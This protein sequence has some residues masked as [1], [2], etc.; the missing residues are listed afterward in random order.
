MT[1]IHNGAV[2]AR[3]FR[4][5]CASALAVA[6]LAAPSAGAAEMV[7]MHDWIAD[8]TQTSKRI[9]AGAAT[10]EQ[11]RE[12]ADVASGDWY[13]TLDVTAAYGYEDIQAAESASDTVLHP[14][15]L[16]LNLTQKL[17]DFG[18]A[19]AEIEAAVLNLN[20][21][22]ADAVSTRQTVILEGV[23]AYLNL[24][25]HYNTL[26][27]ARASVANVKRQ[28]ELEDARVERGSGLSTDVLQA[29]RQ[30]A[31]AEARR[32]RTEGA[33]K[34]AA[35]T[36]LRVFGALPPDIDMMMEPPPPTDMLP[37]TMEDA[38]DIAVKENPQLLSAS[39][40]TQLARAGVDETRSSEFFPEINMIG[41]YSSETNSGGTAGNA[42]TSG[43]RVEMSYSWNLAA[44]AIDSLEAAKHES[45]ST[46]LL[47]ADARDSIEESVRS[48]W[49]RFETARENASFL[50]NQANMASAF[51]DLARRERALGNR[52]LLDVLS[53]ET[54]LQNATS[55]AASAKIDASIALFQ[56]LAAM[57]RLELESI[58]KSDRAAALGN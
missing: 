4:G 35:N 2:K 15:T 57:G 21:A 27:F 46:E 30:L 13:P 38:V 3:C 51:L 45:S 8:L 43:I 39:F 7:H 26:K 23:T 10:V 33:L 1:L 20:R 18:A 24:R 34:T 11:A 53:G 25:R 42:T 58:P 19:D 37:S 47:Y 6:L 36:F 44:T 55:D 54:E 32:V 49:D 12:E 40:R 29:K 17:W 56:L 5:A 22:Q 52:S 31:G 9:Q 14:R 48:A 50:D 28:L 41:E 16:D